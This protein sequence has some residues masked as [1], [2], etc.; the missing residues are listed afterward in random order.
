M[1]EFAAPV[2][3]KQAR[4]FFF[5][6]LAEP[7]QMIRERIAEILSR[8]ENILSVVQ[9][10]ELPELFNVV[11][12][13]EPDFIFV[14]LALIKERQTVKDIRKYAANCRIMALTDSISEPYFNVIRRLELDGIV[15]KSRV[16]DYISQ[17]VQLHKR[18]EKG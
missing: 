16:C 7:N 18:K 10:G 12:E 15:E 11:K 8:D 3:I 5:I 13:T 2:Y 4:C 9:I 17:E 14:S 6:V 1:V